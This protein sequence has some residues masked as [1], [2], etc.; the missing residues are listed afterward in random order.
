M[1]KAERLKALAG[2]KEI[3]DYYLRRL[4]TAEEQQIF[5]DCADGNI[6]FEDFKEKLREI[7]F[8]L[9]KNDLN[10]FSEEEELD[11]VEMSLSEEEAKRLFG[12]KRLINKEIIV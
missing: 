8:E 3:Y 5:D 11:E 10:R 1:D 7:S 6:S 4:M 12:N 9:Y 2:Y